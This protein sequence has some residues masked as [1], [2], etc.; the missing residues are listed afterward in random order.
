MNCHSGLA[1]NFR[2]YPQGISSVHRRFPE[3]AWT[4][5]R[6]GGSPSSFIIGAKQDSP[7]LYSRQT[8]LRDIWLNGLNSQGC[9]KQVS[10]WW[11][12]FPEWVSQ[13]GRKES[14]SKVQAKQNWVKIHRTGI[15]HWTW[16]NVS[17]KK[18]WETREKIRQESNPRSWSG[19]NS[20]TYNCAR[21]KRYCSILK[22]TAK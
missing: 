5:F 7:D 3:R 20:G 22:K 12:E 18:T 1:M 14:V 9:P 16:L 2:E 8:S 13:T 6:G 15:L 17:Q 21:E 4:D 11:K 10:W 19:E